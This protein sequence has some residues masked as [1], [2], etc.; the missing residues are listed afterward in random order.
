MEVVA[1]YQRADVAWKVG[2]I[3]LKYRPIAPKPASSCSSGAG[4]AGAGALEASRTT[5]GKRKSCA[6]E[7]KRERKSTKKEESSTITTLPL[8]PETPERKEEPA[9][10]PTTS[11]DTASPAASFEGHVPAPPRFPCAP[12]WQVVAPR[13][14]R[15]VGSW[16]TVEKVTDTWR[17]GEPVLWDEEAV[18]RILERDTCPA[19]VSDELEAV[20][21]TNSAYKKMV[22]GTTAT[23]EEVEEEEGEEE[24]R[25]ALVSRAGMVPEGVTCFT[26]RVRVRYACRSRRGT[27]SMAAPC[28]VWRLADGKLVWRLDVKAA[29]SL[30][31]GC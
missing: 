27:M 20:T 8:M 18:K 26:C 19:F 5:R 17:S 1:R 30:G 4:A 21:W 11:S 25:V 29:L 15:P 13:P 6:K 12:T 3:M 31:L 16:V 14:V 23:A 24:V 28:D 9:P 10:A 2:R 22:V 7:C